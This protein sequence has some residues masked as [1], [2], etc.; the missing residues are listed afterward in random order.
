MT[1]DEVASYKILSLLDSSGAPRI[2]YDRLVAL[3][4]K[5]SKT[6]FEVRKAINRDTLMKRLSKYKARPRI[7]IQSIKNQEVFRFMFQDMLQDLLHSCSQHLHIISSVPEQCNLEKG[8]E[9]ELW[10]TQW[11]LNT[12]ATEQYKNFNSNNDIMLPIIL[13]MDKTGTD[14]NQRYSLE[15]VLFSL[16][17]LPR[18]QRESRHSWR[19]L[20]FILPRDN[21]CENETTSNIPSI[22]P[23][24]PFIFVGWVTRVTKEPTNRNNKFTPWQQH[25]TESNVTTDG[26]HGRP[27]FPGHFMWSTEVK[28]WWSWSS[29]S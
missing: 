22:L 4:K 8:T 10:N 13:Y 18:E 23:R 16:A 12:F 11:M 5:L 27:T 24:L 2:C 28:F 17:A 20:G 21:S 25:S 9:H 15:P 6:G 19:H 29:T 14:V 1:R 7:Q 3:L 26:S